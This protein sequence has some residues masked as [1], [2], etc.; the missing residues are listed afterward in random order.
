MDLLLCEPKS[1][2]AHEV[3]SK[4]GEVLLKQERLRR[5]DLEMVHLEDVLAFLDA[6]LNGLAAVV[7]MEPTIQIGGDI[8]ITVVHKHGMAHGLAGLIAS[9]GEIRPDR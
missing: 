5:S 9:Q 3:G 4:A 2:K 1:G 6:G 7:T 8:V